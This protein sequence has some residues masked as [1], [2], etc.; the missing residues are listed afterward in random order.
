MRPL[1]PNDASKMILHL[2]KTFLAG[3]R[4]WNVTRAAAEVH[5]AQSNVSGQVRSFE[6]EPGYQSVRSIKKWG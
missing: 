1:A 4:S 2:L 5:C 3:A 6:T